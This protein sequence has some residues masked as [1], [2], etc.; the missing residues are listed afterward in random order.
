[1]YYPFYSLLASIR[2]VMTAAFSW[3]RCAI[4]IVGLLMGGV[5]NVDAQQPEPQH[6]RV[7]TLVLYGPSGPHQA[8]D[9]TSRSG[10]H[11]E[12]ALHLSGGLLASGGAV[13]GGIQAAT[14]LNEGANRS[15]GAVLAAGSV[16]L[17]VAGVLLI[18]R[19]IQILRPDRD[20]DRAYRRSSHVARNSHRPAIRNRLDR[21][22]R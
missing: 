14:L 3:G 4:C 16:G 1:M 19:G 18:R 7:R 8:V 20:S 13:A 2:S 15:I 11:L 9:T 17:G 21:H 12:S 5:W 10:R 22:G 6:T